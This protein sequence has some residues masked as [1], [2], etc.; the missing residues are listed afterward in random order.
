MFLGNT[1]ITGLL[2]M[3]LLHD[4]SKV[5]NEVNP[6][7]EEQMTDQL[8]KLPLLKLEYKFLDAYLINTYKELNTWFQIRENAL[9]A[10]GYI[11]CLTERFI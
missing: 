5:F 3:D 8:N 2:Q 10:W 4:I 1:D 7:F 9:T 6:Y 11:G